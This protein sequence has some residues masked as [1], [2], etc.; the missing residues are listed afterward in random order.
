MNTRGS[1]PSRGGSF[2]N[3]PLALKLLSRFP[4]FVITHERMQEL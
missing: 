4:P 3:A 2:V 1:Q